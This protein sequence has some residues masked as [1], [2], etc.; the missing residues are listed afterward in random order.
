MAI[1][2]RSR[3][4]TCNDKHQSWSLEYVLSVYEKNSINNIFICAL[5]LAAFHQFASNLIQFFGQKNPIHSE[6]CNFTI[7][8]LES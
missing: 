1:M 2:V 6:S 7:S 5:E 3:P 4:G 8:F